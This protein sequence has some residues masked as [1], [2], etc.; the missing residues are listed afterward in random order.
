MPLGERDPRRRFETIR[1]TTS[2]LKETKQA[3]GAEVLAQ[4]AEWT[5][6]TILS[7]ASRMASRALPFNLV[8]TNVPG[9]QVPLYMLGSTMRDNYGFVPLMDGLSLGVVLFSYA[10][11]LC[12]GFTCDWDLLPDLHDFVLDIQT[13][14]RELQRAGAAIELHPAPA[15]AAAGARVSPKTPRR[16][17]TGKR[18]RARANGSAHPA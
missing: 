1:Q 13:S 18:R 12:W 16:P 6:T 5:P 4:V 9:P 11:L 14:F 15:A 8:V 10:G 17:T 3:L 2:E 7:L